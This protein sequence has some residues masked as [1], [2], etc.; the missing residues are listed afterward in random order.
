MSSDRVRVLA[1][2]PDLATLLG[3]EAFRQARERCTAEFISLPAGRLP[4]PQAAP[5]GYLGLLVLRGVLLCRLRVAGRETADVI[6][7]GDVIRPRRLDREW[8]ELFSTTLWRA[9]G[10]VDLARLDRRF[11]RE[12]A[13]WP[14]VGIALAE[15]VADHAWSL[16]VRLAVAQIPQVSLRLQIVLW[17]LADRFGYVDRDGIVVPLR[18]S[19][20]VIAE[21]VSARR[22]AVSRRLMELRDRGVVVPDRG[23]WRLCG[24]RPDSPEAVSAVPQT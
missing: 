12:S 8:P 24:T 13:E 14:E 3:R 16:S 4:Q 9:L 19:H 1:L 15:R 6:G 2:D 22:E 21:L 23:G 18:L 7:P 5:N 20:Q 17:E 10:P 11:M